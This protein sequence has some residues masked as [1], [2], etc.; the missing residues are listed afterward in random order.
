M[1]RLYRFK[2]W[3]EDSRTGTLTPDSQSKAYKFESTEEALARALDLLEQKRASGVANQLP[4]V[5]KVEIATPNGKEYSLR[6][7]HKL[8]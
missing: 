5:G 2:V 7:Y 1:V 8:K 3:F 4:T 6:R